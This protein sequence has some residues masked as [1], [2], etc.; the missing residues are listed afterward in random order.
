MRLTKKDIERA[1]KRRKYSDGRGLFLSVS[2]NGRKTWAFC[3]RF[4]DPSSPRGYRE[5][6]MGLGSL[7]FLSLDDARDRAVEL[8]RMVR[9]GVDPMAERDRDTLAQRYARHLC[10]P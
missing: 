8:R 7:D 10:K 9:Q 1:N 4:P 5:R 2:A 3:Y 6:E